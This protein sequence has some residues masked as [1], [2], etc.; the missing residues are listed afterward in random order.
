MSRPGSHPAPNTR[1][2]GIMQTTWIKSSLSFAN[3]N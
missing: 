1:K 2:D 3:G